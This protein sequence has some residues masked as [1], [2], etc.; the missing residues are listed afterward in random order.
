MYLK[1]D[2][3]A[4]SGDAA[5]RRMMTA[6]MK[7]YA[8]SLAVEHAYVGHPLFEEHGHEV[9]RERLDYLRKV[10]PASDF[11]RTY[12]VVHELK[13]A[14]TVD[15][16]AVCLLA[17][18]ACGADAILNIEDTSLIGAALGCATGVMRHELEK[19]RKYVTLP[20]RP[21]SETV[22]ALRW[23]R[24]APPFAAG[25]GTL[26]VSEERLT[27]VWHCPKRP[28]GLWPDVDE[29]DYCVTAPAAIARNMPLPEVEADGDRPYVLCSVHPDSGALCV[30]VTPRTFGE[31]IDHTP[32]ASIR[33]K[34]GRT[35]SPVG[36]FGR[37]ESLCVEFEEK[38]EGRRVF[39]QNLL[40]DTARD[41]TP[42]V[43]LSDRRLTI[44]GGVIPEDPEKGI[45]A[46][47]IRI[48]RG[49]ILPE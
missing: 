49:D 28:Q 19:V 7:K 8:P 18:H 3:G 1:V 36:L 41:I 43:D 40:S 20:P 32:P 39:A 22:C 10:L 25:R 17:A 6:C 34:G 47:M 46:V 24:I 12:D 31:N 15:R 27:D 44:N 33:V 48:V 23:Q 38:I 21:V 11:L 2:W 29:G 26:A 4:H 42:L 35:D 13:Y 30:A 37:F 45:P 16:A 14:S 5:Y 9:P